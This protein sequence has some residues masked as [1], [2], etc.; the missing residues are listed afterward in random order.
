MQSALIDER[1]RKQI[2]KTDEQLQV[3]T[4]KENT[5]PISMIR[6]ES[7]IVKKTAT[8]SKDSIS[9]IWNQIL[10]R[11]RLFNGTYLFGFYIRNF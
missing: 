11:L 3:S 7:T 4:K 5:I 2:H 1:S 10:K 9:D 8:I 6:K